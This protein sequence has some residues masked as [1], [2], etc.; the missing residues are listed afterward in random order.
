MWATC[1]GVITCGYSDSMKCV[2]SKVHPF[3]APPEIDEFLLHL[4]F[5]RAVRKKMKRRLAKMAGTYAPI[6]ELL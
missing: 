3:S 1:T 6:E 5:C 2:G 4:R